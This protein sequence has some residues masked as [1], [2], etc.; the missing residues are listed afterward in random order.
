MFEHLVCFKF[1]EK[2]NRQNEKQ[3][4]D[5]LMSFKERIPGIVDLT[6]GVNVTEETNN[7]HGYTLGLRVTFQN[8]EALRQYGPHPAH[9]QFVKLLDGIIENVVV[10]DYPIQQ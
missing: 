9:Q 2:Y 10:I 5:T 6:A 3:L 7:I 4:I 8:Q 1:N